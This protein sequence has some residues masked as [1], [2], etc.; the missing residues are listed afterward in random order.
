MKSLKTFL[1]GLSALVAMS[2][3]AAE[4][5]V[6]LTVEG[7]AATNEVQIA[8]NQQGTVIS[9]LDQDYLTGGSDY[10]TRLRIIKDGK[11]IDMRSVTYKEM[12][13]V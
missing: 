3:C 10:Y 11:Q 1:V 9:Y 13:L 5:L 12:K 2:A 7:S 8:A 6:T 4:G